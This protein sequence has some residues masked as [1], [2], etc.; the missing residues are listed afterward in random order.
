M[1]K[2]VPIS[3]VILA[4]PLVEMGCSFGVKPEDKVGSI[5]SDSEAI[6]LSEPVELATDLTAIANQ[7]QKDQ[8][9]PTSTDDDGDEDVEV[10]QET[11]G[12]PAALAKRKIASQDADDEDD[13]SN[14]AE[15]PAQ[16]T[17]LKKI[18]HHSS[19]GKIVQY[20]V[21]KGDTLMKV[22]FELLGDLTRWKE[23]YADNQKIIANPNSLTG[24]LVLN[25]RLSD[26]VNV[27][28]HGVPYSI[29]RGDTLGKVSNWVYGTVARWKDLWH[30]NRELIHNPNW[31]YAG[32]KLYFIP[33]IKQA[34]A[35]AP[36]IPPPVQRTLASTKLPAAEEPIPLPAQQN[37]DGK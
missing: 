31:I 7:I 35:P 34:A 22:S 25:V 9:S 26:V 17:A 33:P 13:S 16:K 11:K 27:H 4:L 8:V 1:R 14:E 6:A 10:N 21:K 12:T 24:G 23:I 37:L 15:T 28:H 29:K 5:A 3:L 30:N 32:F 18:K 36:V 19:S 2:L 20:H